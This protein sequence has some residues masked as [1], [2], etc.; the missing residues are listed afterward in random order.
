MNPQT[1][2]QTAPQQRR[3]RV[4]A[5]NTAAIDQGIDPDE[6]TNPSTSDLREI[7]I[8]INNTMN[9]TMDRFDKQ[10]QS[11]TDIHTRIVTRT[12][13]PAARLAAERRK[14]PRTRS[15][16]DRRNE[17]VAGGAR[18]KTRK[19]RTRKNSRKKRTRRKK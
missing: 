9:K 15:Y 17:Q 14:Q 13:S 10:L 16:S 2:S 7:L 1:A 19:R 5:R 4:G 12:D 8:V 3:R 11:L 18:K 6:T